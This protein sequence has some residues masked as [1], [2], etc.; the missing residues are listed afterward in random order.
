MR[1]RVRRGPTGDPGSPLC[2]PVTHA[3]RAE[4]AIRYAEI[5]QWSSW[6]AEPGGMVFVGPPGTIERFRLL[7]DKVLLADRPA[8]WEALTRP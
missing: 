5:N 2:G 8:V 1:R 7:A 4:L 3:E 6:E